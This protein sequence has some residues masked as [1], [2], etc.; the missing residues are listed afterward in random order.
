LVGGR[1]LRLD[2]FGVAQLFVCSPVLTLSASWCPSLPPLP[3]LPS[4]LS[5]LLLLAATA[6]WPSRV[7]APPDALQRRP[8][9]R[10]RC[11]CFIIIMFA[12]HLSSGW[13]SAEAISAVGPDDLSECSARLLSMETVPLTSSIG[14]HVL[15]CHQIVFLCFS[16]ARTLTWSASRSFLS[17]LRWTAVW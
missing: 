12:K 11:V 14:R 3:S 17:T 4:H 15:P 1:W 5:S 16:V 2:S 9:Q 10:L 13:T 8:N 7:G 6:L